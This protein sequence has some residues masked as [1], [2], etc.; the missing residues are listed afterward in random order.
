M[1]DNNH[2]AFDAGHRMSDIL[3]T[4]EHSDAFPAYR[5]AVVFNHF[6]PNV[7]A[8]VCFVAG[9]LGNAFPSHDKRVIVITPSFTDPQSGAAS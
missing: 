7:S 1:R 5:D 3:G 8:S 6:D 2:F 9:F 4:T